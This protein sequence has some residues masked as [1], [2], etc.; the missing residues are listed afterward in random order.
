MFEQGQTTT[1]FW[2]GTFE[3]ELVLV[4]WAAKS[5]RNVGGEGGA[6]EGGED[7]AKPDN[8]LVCYDQEANGRPVLCVERSPFYPDLVM[9]VHDF[10][11][12]IWKTS[13]PYP[14]NTHP[15]F[16]S[17][18]SFGSHNTSGGFSP[19]RPGVIFITKTDAI[20]VW[21]FYDQSN[22]PSITLPLAT[23]SITY[24]KFQFLSKGKGKKTWQNQIMSYGEFETGNLNLCEVPLNLSKEQDKE[25]EI[26]RAFWDREQEKC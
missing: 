16:K 22:K 10:N 6:A 23:S 24:F 1:T 17:A 14:E 19:T 3:G 7:K 9:T 20:D 15:I 21:D 5:G 25:A 26:I 13:L 18:N 11:F 12:C 4:D 8:I 2:A